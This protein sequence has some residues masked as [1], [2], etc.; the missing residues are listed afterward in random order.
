M[1][2]RFTLEWADYQN[3]VATTFVN[4]RISQDFTDV[5][6]VGKDFELT[7]RFCLFFTTVRPLLPEKTLNS[8]Y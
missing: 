3:S 5:T 8:S 2:D 4:A 6:L 1:G 7:A